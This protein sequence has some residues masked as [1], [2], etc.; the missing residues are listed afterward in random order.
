MS[1]GVEYH[2]QLIGDPTILGWLTF[3]GYLMASIACWRALRSGLYPPGA[4]PHGASTRGQPARLLR[5]WWLGVGLLMLL[6]GLNKQ[7]D[8]QTLFAQ[9]AKSM[10]LAEGWYVRRRQVQFAF[11]VTLALALISLALAAIYALRPVLRHIVPSLLGLALLLLFV[12]LRAVTFH[13]LRVPDGAEKL[14]GLWLAELAGIAL[15]AWDAR[16]AVRGVGAKPG[17]R[18]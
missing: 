6:L 14:P 3:A 1:D 5:R 7:L 11:V 9:L 2:W 15:I 16:R 17:N 18:P 10:A 4:S 13:V 8:L 12:G